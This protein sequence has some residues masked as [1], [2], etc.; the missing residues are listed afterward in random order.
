MQAASERLIAMPSIAMCVVVVTVI[1]YYLPKLLYGL[2]VVV[3]LSRAGHSVTAAASRAIDHVYSQVPVPQRADAGICT[4]WAL[5]ALPAVLQQGITA[6]SGACSSQQPAD[7]QLDALPRQSAAFDYP[8]HKVVYPGALR[9]EHVAPVP[10]APSSNKLAQQA[11][12][13]ALVMRA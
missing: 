8:S 12:W 9:Q 10:A 4:R 3:L 7:E 1:A 13:P 6:S 2:M 11:A 5:C